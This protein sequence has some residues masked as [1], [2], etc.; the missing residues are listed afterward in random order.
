MSEVDWEGMRPPTWPAPEPLSATRPSWA[1]ITAPTSIVP[2][3]PPPPPPRRLPSMGTSRPDGGGEWLPAVAV[4]AA[5]PAGGFAFA[6]S[7]GDEPQLDGQRGPGHHWQRLDEDR[8]SERD[9]TDRRGRG[10][11]EPGGG[12]DRDATR[13]R[14]GLRVRRR[15]DTSSPPPMSSK[16][17]ASPSM[18]V[19]P[20]APCTRARSSDPTMRATS[21]S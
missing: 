11:R 19:S 2:P 20:T 16:A 15:R 4:S 3:P 17:R 7:T 13:T 6:R 9:E 8:R 21:R 14:F 18:C 12:A 1:P 5:L 10:G